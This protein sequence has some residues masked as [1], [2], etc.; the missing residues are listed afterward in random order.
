M[1]QDHRI[2]RNKKMKTSTAKSSI[3]YLALLS[4]LTSYPI[5]ADGSEPPIYKDA[6]QPTEER[7]KDLLGRM[8]LEEKV[9]QMVCVWQGKRA[10]LDKQGDFVA[11]NMAQDYPDSIGCIAR[12]QDVVGLG[13]AYE[14]PARNAGSSVSLV[15]AIQKYMLEETRLGIPVLFHEEGLHGLQAKDATVFPQ[16]IALAST[17]NIDLIED[18]YSIV[19]REIRARGVH[20]VLSPVIDVARD[21]RWGRIEE[22]FGEDPYLVSRMGV[23][24]VKGFQ[25]TTRKLENG[26]VFTTLKHM[27]GHGQPES[28]TN[29]APANISTRIL[30]EVFFPPFEAAIKEANAATVMA[31]YNEIDGVPSHGSKFLLKDVLRDE[32]G[33]EGVIVSDYFAIDQLNTMH[34]VTDSDKGS[35]ILAHSVGVDMELPDPHIYL[36]LINLVKIGQ[37]SEALINQSVSKILTLKFNAGMF[38]NPYADA[39]LA[40]KITGNQEARELALKA[41]HQSITLLKNEDQLLP[42]DANAQQLIAVIGPNADTVV[43][44]GY[45]DQPRQSISILQGI[46]DKLGDSKTVLYAEGARITENASWKSWWRDEVVFADRDENLERIEQAVEVANKADKIVLVVGG[47]EATSREAYQDTHLGD[48]ASLQLIGEQQQ[49]FDALHATGKPVIVVLINGLPLSVTKIS[50]TAPAIIEGWILCQETGTAVADVLFGDVN[51]SGKLPVSIPRSAGHLP[52]FYNYKP[53]A[54]RG[55]VDANINAL[56][57][58]GYGLSYTNFDYSKPILEQNVIAKHGSFTVSLKIKNT[59]RIAGDE[60]VQLYIRDQASS[61]TRPVKELK[62]FKRVSL[63]AGQAKQVV[64]KL[65]ASDSLAFYD[66]N[67]QRTV[68]PGFFDIMV[69]S[70]SEN[71]KTAVLEVK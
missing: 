9:S 61:V 46:R 22:T 54:R 52:V 21:P 62:A 66:I 42:L 27:T 1:Y 60:I 53:T 5:W 16:S 59:G 40:E 7:V 44:G 33:F 70:S 24:A 48:R 11:S 47:N 19:A 56:Y 34:H 63:A 43:L 57:P 55:Y 64:F 31:S 18:V 26:K 41:A 20:H 23:A 49:L 32:W 45:S 12:P 37:H 15:N 67:M 71:L 39:E 50:E 3:K 28:G 2:A 35:A 36:K 8:T 68:E 65:N 58:F 4:I 51:P 29:I 13:N 25:G 30:R 6:R 38:D 10:F 69:G 17:W 14:T